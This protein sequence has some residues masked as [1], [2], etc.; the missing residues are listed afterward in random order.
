MKLRKNKQKTT[1]VLVRSLTLAH[2]GNLRVPKVKQ[3]DSKFRSL[4][5]TANRD[6]NRWQAHNTPPGT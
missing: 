6:L 3:I 5:E 4:S 1:S 2:E